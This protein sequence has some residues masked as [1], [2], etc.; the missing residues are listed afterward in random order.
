MRFNSNDSVKHK[1]LGCTMRVIA[2][3]GPWVTCEYS[4][5][6][7]ERVEKTYHKESL[8]ISQKNPG[9]NIIATD[10]DLI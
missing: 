7:G 5:E 10:L 9:L 8:I 6:N 4:D 1:S 3:D 2:I